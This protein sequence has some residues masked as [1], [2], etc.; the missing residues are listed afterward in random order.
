M[1]VERSKE[2]RTAFG[3]PMPK[4]KPCKGSKNGAHHWERLKRN[5]F[6]KCS[7]CGEPRFAVRET[8]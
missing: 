5:Q 3:R 7:C 8:T 6:E 1:T 2:Q 4:Y